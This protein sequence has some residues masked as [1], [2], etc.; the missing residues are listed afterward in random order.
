MTLR[1]SYHTNK[2]TKNAHSLVLRLLLERKCYIV[3]T[4]LNEEPKDLYYAS[5]SSC[6]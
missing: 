2:Q 4:A 5:N 3:N 1:L 6:D